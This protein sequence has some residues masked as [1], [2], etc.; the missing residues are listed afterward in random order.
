MP[1]EITKTTTMSNGNKDA[2]I[3]A[4]ERK[5]AELSGIELDQIKKN[6]VSDL[7]KSYQAIALVVAC[8]CQLGYDCHFNSY[9]SSMSFGIGNF[10]QLTSTIMIL[11]DLA[12]TWGY[13]SIQ[14]YYL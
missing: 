8:H 13:F 3:A 1:T 14:Y 11:I 7:K 2:Y 5:L 6:Q 10:D 4:L 12:G 9:I